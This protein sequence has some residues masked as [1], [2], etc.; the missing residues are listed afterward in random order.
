MVFL[1]QWSREPDLEGWAVEN[2]AVSVAVA[3]F[4]TSLGVG[5][6][7]THVSIFEKGKPADARPSVNLEGCLH[8]D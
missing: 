2:R 7:L 5:A 6:V 8:A 4:H 3:G 1:G